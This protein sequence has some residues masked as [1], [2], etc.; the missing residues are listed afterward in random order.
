SSEM[1]NNIQDIY[2]YI[3]VK[4]YNVSKAVSIIEAEMPVTPERDEI[5]SFIAN[6]SR[7]IMKGLSRRKSSD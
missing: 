6:S 4:G 2:R 7:G 3:F 1:I 5:L